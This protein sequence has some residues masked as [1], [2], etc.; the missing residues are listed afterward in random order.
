MPDL[1]IEVDHDSGQI[2]ISKPIDEG[3]SLALVFSLDEIDPDDALEIFM[4]A[5]ELVLSGEVCSDI[6]PQ[7]YESN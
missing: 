1:N 5:H 4:D 6:Y 3:T 7:D 2:F